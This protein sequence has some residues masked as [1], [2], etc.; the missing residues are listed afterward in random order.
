MEHVNDT[1]YSMN[2]Q[3]KPQKVMSKNFTSHLRIKADTR[4]HRNLH[5][6]EGSAHNWQ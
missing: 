2:S 4:N 3:M 6:Q 1:G 5:G